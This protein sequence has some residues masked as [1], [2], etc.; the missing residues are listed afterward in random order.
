MANPWDTGIRLTRIGIR[1]RIVR[2]KPS[3]AFS[4]M[5]GMILL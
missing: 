4:M 1:S 3:A 2:I 5:K